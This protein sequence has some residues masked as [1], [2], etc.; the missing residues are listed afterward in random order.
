MQKRYQPNGSPAFREYNW[1][2]NGVVCL[3]KYNFK[4]PDHE[5]VIQAAADM[6]EI[7]K[8]EQL[9]PI[10]LQE[11]NNLLAMENNR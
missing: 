8:N 7:L 5:Q 9:R 6:I 11:V 10:S 2:Q 4:P 1:L 3:L